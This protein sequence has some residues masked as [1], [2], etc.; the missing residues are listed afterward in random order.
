MKNPYFNAEIKYSEKSSNDNFYLHSH[1]EYEIYMFLEGN[2]NCIVEDKTYPLVSGDMLIIRKNEMHKVYHNK[3]TAYKRF[4]LMVSGEF[5]EKYACKEYENVFT[6]NT[7]D[8]SNKINA[9]I[10]KSSGL[11]DAIQRFK[12][13]TSDCKKQ[14]TPVAVGII[15]E[16]LYLI[17]NISS[18]EPPAK[19][20]KL[21]KNVISYI[22]SNIKKDLSLE[23]LSSEFF[24]SKYHLCHSFKKA[25]GLTIKEYVNTKRLAKANEAINEGKTITE[26]ALLSG[27][28][29]YS[30]FYR[31]YIKNNSASP[32]KSIRKNRD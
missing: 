23:R 28:K 8:E 20:S 6:D 17:N 1:N 4:I 32:S 25:T 2:S 21:I 12:N 5:F 10:V 9:E 26:A 18:F 27:F 15:T 7:F 29:D 16:I 11:Y 22:N 3:K 30:S 19:G 13:Y 14:H 24:V 31:C